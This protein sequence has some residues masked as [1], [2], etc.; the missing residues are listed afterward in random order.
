MISDPIAVT[1]GEPAGIGAEI[2]L[3]A[4]MRREELSLPAFVLLDD[5]KRLARLAQTLEWPIEI[6]EIDSP[7]DAMS[8]FSDQLPVLP[9]PLPGGITPGSPDPAN[10]QTVIAAVEEGVDL[11]RRGEAAA[12]VTNPIHKRVLYDAGFRHPG[13]TEFLAE[14]AGEEARP[15]MMLACP[16]LRV[17]PVTVHLALRDA[18][19]ALN[20]VE[21]ESIG[22]IVS[23]ALTKDFGIKKPQLAVAAVNPHAGEDG[24]M[25]REEIN[26]IAPAIDTLKREGVL[27][28]GP[29][30]ADTLFHERARST[31]DAAICMYHDQA[32]IPLKTID[33]H[34]GINIT[35]GL[36]FVRT[37]PDHG[38][39]LEIAGTGVADERSFAAAVREAGA[40]AERRAASRSSER[41]LDS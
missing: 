19:A 11:I 5:P 13:H 2:C 15:V 17:V 25:G 29:A 20:Q 10:A 32:L 41:H 30:P 16:G 40:I 18:I 7:K 14:L 38:T 23:R 4:W 34:A 12:L 8:V 37:S 35:L 26:I 3:K 24:T 9:R 6:A 27:V 28:L 39:A 31:Y 33:F 22:R 36:P 21:I 1:M